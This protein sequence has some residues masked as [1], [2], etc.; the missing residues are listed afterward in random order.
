MGE[1]MSDDGVQ[2]RPDRGNRP[3]RRDRDDWDRDDFPED[4]P[5]PKMVSAAGIIWIVFGGLILVTAAFGLIRAL[6]MAPTTRGGGALFG[7]A[8]CAVA[9]IAFIGGAFLFVGVQSVRGT[10]ADTL[11]N[12]IGSIILGALL[13]LVTMFALMFDP[14]TGGVYLLSGGGL[15]AAGVLALVGRAD[16]NLWKRSQGR[17][18]F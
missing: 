18:R 3:A 11:G 5:F 16:Y 12:G 1:A 6:A 10:A 17:R 8:V 13:L 15:V 9:F 14:V 2:D 4:V 7:G